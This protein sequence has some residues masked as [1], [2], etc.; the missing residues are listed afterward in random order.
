M[1]HVD[2]QIITDPKVAAVLMDESDRSFLGR[3][4]HQPRTVS[5]VA[6]EVGQER[7]KV[8]YRVRKLLKLGILQVARLE[9]RVGRPIKHYQ[10]SAQ[11]YVVPYAVSPMAGAAEFVEQLE[12][13]LRDTF[14]ESFLSEVEGHLV[15]V[16]IGAS[17]DAIHP[18]LGLVFYVN[19]E[20]RRD[21]AQQHHPI[22]LLRLMVLRLPESKAMALNRDLLALLERYQAEE[23][24]DAPAHLLRLGLVKLRKK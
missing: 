9:P 16:E 1:R 15:G 12:G 3:F 5:D 21:R 10:T 17:S 2:Q 20:W 13:T 23:V 6:R 19:G 24:P 11:R 22:N 14:Y 8:L 7:V 18:S 4:F